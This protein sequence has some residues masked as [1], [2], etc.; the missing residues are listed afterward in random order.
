M[1]CLIFILLVF[2]VLGCNAQKSDYEQIMSETLE[3]SE[4]KKFLHLELENRSPVFLYNN[5]WIE[6]ELSLEGLSYEVQIVDDTTGTN[7]NVIRFSELH[8]DGDSA[9]FSL[10]YKIENMS[11][12]GTVKKSNGEWKVESID[13]I[14]EF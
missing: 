8:V 12:A 13:E 2:T 10:Y 6:D 3:N 5:E 7:G 1:K 4:L 14:I 11:M 9:K